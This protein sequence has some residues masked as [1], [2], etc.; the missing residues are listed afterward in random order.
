[1]TITNMTQ[2]PNMSQSTTLG[3]MSHTLYTR[4]TKAIRLLS[5]RIAGTPIALDLNLSMHTTTISS[6]RT[7]PG[8]RCIATKL[9]VTLPLEL[10]AEAVITDPTVE[11]MMFLD[12]VP[13]SI[14]SRLEISRRF[15]L[16]DEVEG[17]ETKRRFGIVCSKFSIILCVTDKNSY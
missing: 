16:H 6:M 15:I 14:A 3:T 17:D 1:M 2:A 10:R 9:M 13:C 5:Q 8:P 12:T 4:V 11:A 7:L